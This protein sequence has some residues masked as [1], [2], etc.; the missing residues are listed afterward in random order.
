MV[1]WELCF[2][3]TTGRKLVHSATSSHQSHN[4]NLRICWRFVRGWP[5][6]D[7]VKAYQ[8]VSARSFHGDGDDG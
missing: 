3:G 8:T 7:T 6:G 1:V 5:R 2:P 4:W